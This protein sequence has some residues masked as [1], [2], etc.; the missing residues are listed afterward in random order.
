MTLYLWIV[1]PLQASLVCS[2]RQSTA[3]FV[4][5]CIT[6]YFWS[7]W[8]VTDAFETAWAITAITLNHLGTQGLTTFHHLG[9]HR[10]PPG[11]GPY[12][13]TTRACNPISH[14]PCHTAECSSGTRRTGRHAAVAWHVAWMMCASPSEHVP[15]LN[16]MFALTIFI[17]P[18]PIIF[19]MFVV[20]LRK[21]LRRDCE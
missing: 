18:M 5:L 9:R 6:L 15:S 20:C 14:L 8:S 7:V 10:T 4:V 11:H 16:Y 13:S 2:E 1:G 21:I 19:I 17:M 12:C 3:P